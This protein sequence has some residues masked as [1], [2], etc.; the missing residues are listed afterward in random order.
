MKSNKV[1][2]YVVKVYKNDKFVGYVKSYR[3]LRTDLYSFERTKNIN[4]SIKYLSIIESCRLKIK[5]TNKRDK[6]RYVNY[7]FDNVI[8]SEQEIRLSKLNILK[9]KKIKTGLFKNKE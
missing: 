3:K 7:Y 5:L 9:T 8:I 2:M 4:E 1:N 6:L